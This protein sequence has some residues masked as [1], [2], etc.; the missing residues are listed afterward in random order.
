[1]YLTTTKLGIVYSMSL[2]SNLCIMQ[3]KLHFRAAKKVLR[4]I[5]DTIEFRVWLEN[6]EKLRLHG[7][8][9]NDWVGLGRVI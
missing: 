4:Y 6:F 3:V 1:M 8:S 7:F 2:L 5:K 9:D